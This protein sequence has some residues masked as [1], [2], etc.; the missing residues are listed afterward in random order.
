MPGTYRQKHKFNILKDTIKWYAV[1]FFT[2]LPGTDLIK[3]KFNYLG[4]PIIPVLTPLGDIM[5]EDAMNL[6]FQWGIEAFPFRK[7]DGI[8]L[9]LKWKWFWDATKKANL[10]IQQVIK[11]IMHISLLLF[12]HLIRQNI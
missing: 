6:I 5:N 10:G 11:H 4:K 1:E 9:T 7:I 12:N 2:E 3:E 8:E